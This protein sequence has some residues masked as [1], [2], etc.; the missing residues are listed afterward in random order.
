[1][2]DERKERSTSKSLL[3][4]ETSFH[5]V[6]LASDGS[7]V[8][9]V[10]PSLASIEGKD[11]DAYSAR[12]VSPNSLLPASNPNLALLLPLS[13]P[14]TDNRILPPSQLLA[15]SPG[16]LSTLLDRLLMNIRGSDPRHSVLSSNK[17][18]RVREEGEGVDRSW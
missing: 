9:R 18:T 11:E 15:H 1:M 5:E 13:H 14:H 12:S 16:H 4:R 3:P 6:L 8:F 17:E 2:A 10:E 7:T